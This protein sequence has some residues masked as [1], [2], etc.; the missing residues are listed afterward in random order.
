MTKKIRDKIKREIV[1]PEL[2]KKAEDT[3]GKILKFDKE[4]L[5]ADVKIMNP[6]TGMESEYN[7]VLICTSNEDGFSGS[8]LKKGDKVIVGFESGDLRNP[9]I[10]EKIIRDGLSFIQKKYESVK[11]VF[12]SDVFSLF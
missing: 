1:E 10:K 11:G 5:V 4:N 2:K 6:V 12:T 3:I 8:C 9:I 7:N